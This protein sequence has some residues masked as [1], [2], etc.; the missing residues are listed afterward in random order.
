M[1][2][3]AQCQ[4]QD[5]ERSS[6]DRVGEQARIKALLHQAALTLTKIELVNGLPL[7][8][9]RDA[10]RLPSVRGERAIAAA[11]KTHP[12][13]LWPSRYR[14]NGQRRKPLDSSRVPALKQRRKEEVQL[15]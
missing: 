11:L 5:E 2:A 8:T 12:H 4:K 3:A 9:C 13:L 15:A 14:P 10:L 6:F 1:P 7:G